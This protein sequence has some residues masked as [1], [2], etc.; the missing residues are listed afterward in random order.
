MNDPAITTTQPVKVSFS[1]IVSPNIS[2]RLQNVITLLPPLAKLNVALSARNAKQATEFEALCE[3]CST[4]FVCIVL[5]TVYDTAYKPEV[6]L[7]FDKLLKTVIIGNVSAVSHLRT[8]MTNAMQQQI[9]N[10]VRFVYNSDSDTLRFFYI[11]E[12]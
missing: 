11:D 3:C 12:D 1:P 8:V 5:T 2:E 10:T 7:Q 9:D 6:I 4:T